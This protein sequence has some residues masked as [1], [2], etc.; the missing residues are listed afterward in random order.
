MPLIELAH[1]ESSNVILQV[2]S[3]GRNLSVVF[4]NVLT[5]NEIKFLEE[6]H[7]KLLFRAAVGCKMQSSQDKRRNRRQNLRQIHLFAE[8]FLD[9]L[10][11]ARL[12][13][14]T[15]LWPNHV[16]GDPDPTSTT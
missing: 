6:L 5:L 15:A 13:D 7:L 2:Q 12:P 1:N 10:R 4:N 16:E 14:Q 8:G 9:V 11:A 3:L